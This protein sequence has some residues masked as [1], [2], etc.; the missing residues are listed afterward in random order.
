DG[1]WLQCGLRVATAHTRVGSLL[2]G[3]YQ[4]QVRAFVADPGRHFVA[5]YRAVY[6]RLG[7]PIEEVSSRSF[8]DRPD[9]R[10]ASLAL[11]NFLLGLAQFT[12]TFSAEILG[13]NL[14][15]QFLDL[16]AFGPELIRD[17]CQA[18]AL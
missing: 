13:V 14:A 15:W 5:D 9:F 18:Y 6:G 3:L 17:T 4:H 10:E 7:A 16:S 8:A 1:C 12:R 11:P 2:I